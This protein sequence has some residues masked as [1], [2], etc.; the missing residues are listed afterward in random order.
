MVLLK[1]RS[2]K[3]SPPRLLSSGGA[4]F[5]VLPARQPGTTVFQLILTAPQRWPWLRRMTTALLG[6][7]V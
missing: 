6:R 7:A 2:A 1:L 4:A 5:L 3:I